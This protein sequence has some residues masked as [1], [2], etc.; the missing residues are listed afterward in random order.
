M[1]TPYPVNDWTSQDPKSLK[2]NWT[3]VVAYLDGKEIDTI[4]APHEDAMDWKDKA[5]AAIEKRQI[6]KDRVR[7]TIWTRK[8]IRQ[9]TFIHKSKKNKEATS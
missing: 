5:L 9:E 8:G 6:A 2:Y 1:K 3:R 4:H 7:F